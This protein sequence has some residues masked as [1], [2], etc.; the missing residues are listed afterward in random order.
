MELEG[1]RENWHK[2]EYSKGLDHFREPA[3]KG[4][5]KVGTFSYTPWRACIS[6]SS[7]S[8][9]DLSVPREGSS[10][11]IPILYKEILLSLHHFK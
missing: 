2:E 9:A 11:E 10:L 6:S 1:W 5:G 3:Y 8:W 4:R 7:V